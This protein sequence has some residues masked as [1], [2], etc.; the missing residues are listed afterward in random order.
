MKKIEELKKKTGFDEEVI[1]CFIHNFKKREVCPAASNGYCK[2][3]YKC[4]NMNDDLE[5]KKRLKRARI[6]AMHTKD[7]IVFPFCIV[8]S[9]RPEL[10]GHPWAIE[11]HFLCWHLRYTF[12]KGE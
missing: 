9:Q 10:M 2:D 6:N 8:I 12:L 4:L 5:R 11:L 7:W 3:Y 1:G